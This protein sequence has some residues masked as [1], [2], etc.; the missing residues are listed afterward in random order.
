MNTLQIIFQV[1]VAIATVL[2]ILQKEKWKMMLC[3]IINNIFVMAMYFTFGQITPACIAIVALIRTIVFMLYAL[4]KIKPN[5]VWLIVFESAFVAT[6]IF[7]WS[8][9]LD[10]MPM[11]ALLAA[12]YGSWQ[13]NY[14]ILRSSYIVNKILYVIYDFIIGA[15]IAMAVEAVNFI[16]TIISLI[17]YSILKKQ[18]PILQLIFKE[19]KQKQIKTITKDDNSKTNDELKLKT[20]KITHNNTENINNPKF[21]ENNS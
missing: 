21:E 11:F 19:K 9:P 18:T 13:D 10:L 3:Y 15:Y 20:S 6:T 8:S 4:K 16:Y 5:V 14:A 17:Y 1:C 7:T 2:A 12:G